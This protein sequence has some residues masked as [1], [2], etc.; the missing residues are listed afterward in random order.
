MW[1]L[2]VPSIGRRRV[3][4]VIK[5]PPGITDAIRCNS[6]AEAFRFSITPHMIDLVVT[7]TNDVRCLEGH[8]MMPMLNK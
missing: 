1:Q 2:H 5:Q 6:M 7:E 3:Q 8:G 4:D